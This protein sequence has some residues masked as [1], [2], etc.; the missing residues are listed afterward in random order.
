[1][2]KVQIFG[3][4]LNYFRKN[5]FYENDNKGISHIQLRKLLEDNNI[6]VMMD[7]RCFQKFL[8][9]QERRNPGKVFAIMVS[10]TPLNLEE[11]I[12]SS[13]FQMSNTGGIALDAK[14]I[15]ENF[16][17]YNQTYMPE[18]IIK[19]S[20]WLLRFNKEE[21]EKYGGC[22]YLVKGN[23]YVASM[24]DPDK[25]LITNAEFVDSMNIKNF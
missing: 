19:E 2:E 8:Y 21:I 6:D 15:S 17:I 16:D 13:F 12:P 5:I 3:L 23:G 11:E 18:L 20:G 4:E 7:T 25:Q 1:M 22:F 10:K 24:I 9:K 14:P